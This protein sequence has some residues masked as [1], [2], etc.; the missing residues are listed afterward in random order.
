[1]VI[2]PSNE[3]L[4]AKE[5]VIWHMKG[6]ILYICNELKINCMIQRNQF[7]T[8]R[9]YVNFN[10]EF[11]TEDYLVCVKEFKLRKWIAKL[12]LRKQWLQ[13]EKGSYTIPNTLIEAR[14]CFHCNCGEVA[15]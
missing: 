12:R 10:K 8:F 14:L 9:L 1:M 3:L 15:T 11:K 4:N 2:D 13:R 7:P 5:R 6:H